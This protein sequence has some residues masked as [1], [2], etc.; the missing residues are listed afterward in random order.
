MDSLDEKI[1]TDLVS[2]GF[3]K[4]TVLANLYG[5]SERTIRRRIK[6]IIDS[7]F[8]KAVV[9]PNFVLLG[10]RAWARIGIRVEPGALQNVARELVAHPSIYF[11]GYTL[12]TYDIILSVYFD[13][14]DKLTYFVNTELGKV[15]GIRFVETMLL[16]NPRKY[17]LFYWP[18]PSSPN[19]ENIFDNL[20]NPYSHVCHSHYE[21]QETDKKILK[22]L[23]E[24]GPVHPRSLSSR[25]G[26]GEVTIL[27]R[28]KAMQRNNVYKILVL[29]LMETG[30]FGAQATIGVNIN[31]HL[32][33][34]FVDSIIE[35]P[36][37]HL[38]SVALGKFNIVI[39]VRCH[40]I[41]LLHQFVTEVLSSKPGIISVETCLH[42]KRIKYYNITF[43]I[44]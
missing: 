42:V 2:K 16:V 31:H 38:A 30:R 26:I 11:M 27:K 22:I 15:K 20:H 10:F 23:M 8:V 3:Q 1:I 5:L 33:H 32:P 28:L 25:L 43:P 37:V 21:L 34:K 6:N 4:S 40:D 14:I 29:P 9:A 12:G 36:F 24:E 18:K 39:G 44:P 17:D 35:H 41:N 13:T 19:S 7:K